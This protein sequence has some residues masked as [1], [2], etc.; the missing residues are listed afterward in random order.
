MKN[1]FGH[2]ELIESI[3][4][5]Q[6][7]FANEVYKKILDDD[8]STFT[9]PLL[10]E[11]ED[12]YNQIINAYNNLTSFQIKVL[13]NVIDKLNYVK[14]EIDPKRLKDFKHC[15]NE[16]GDLLL[17]RESDNGLI[18]IIIHT[19]EDIAYSFIGNTQGNDLD[20]Y[21]INNCD[22]EKLIFK[23]LS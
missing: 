17:Y 15:M 20:F 22:F 10:K 7:D 13:T 18:N 4:S 6:S 12:I 8:E 19:E 16:D 1:D 9:T 14:T 23:F 2:I 5:A 21:T 11:V 3:K